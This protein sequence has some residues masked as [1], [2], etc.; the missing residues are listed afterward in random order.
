MTERVLYRSRRR[1]SVVFAAH[2]AAVGAFATRI[3]WLQQHLGLSDSTL[4]LALLAPALGSFGAVPFTSR[5]VHRF[6]NPRALTCLLPL[7]CASLILPALAPNLPALCVALGLFG[8]ASGMMDVLMNAQGVQVEQRLNQPLIAGLHGIWAVGGLVSSGCGALAASAGMDARLHF[9][10]AAAVLAGIGLLATRRHLLESD[11]TEARQPPPRFALP[12]LS[13]LPIGIL[14]FCAVFAE[15]ASGNWSAVYL[16]STA[17]ASEGVAALSYTG[18]SFTLALAR[19]SSGFVVS[20][21][22]PVRT[23]RLSGGIAALGGTLVVLAR[24]PPVAIAGFALI[25]TGVAVVLPLSLSAAGRHG[26]DPSRHIAGVATFT[27]T[28]SLLAPSVTGAVADATSL[29]AAFALVT[30]FAAGPLFLA[31]TLAGPGRP[32]KGGEDAPQRVDLFS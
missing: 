18:L 31:G 32:P 26:G 24:T 13:T 25:G 5:L 21:L 28:S 17:H 6:G 15:G 12:P 3:P 22:G 16:S 30:A 1:I 2:G 20:R 27:Y 10:V 14:G 8:A 19:L 9:A 11:P 7:W 4:G 29:P 23:V